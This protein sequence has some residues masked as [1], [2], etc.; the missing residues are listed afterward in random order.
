MLE[1][2]HLGGRTLPHAVLMM[3]PEA[4]E[5]NAT[6]DPAIRGFAE[7]HASLIEPWD[8][9]AC[10]TFTDGT[11]LGAVLDRNGLRP[12]RWWLTTDDTVVLASE[13]G[14]LP[15]PP[16]KVLERGRLQPGRMFLVDTDQGRILN[17]A[18]VKGALAAEHPYRDWVHAGL[19][20]L[21]DLPPREHVTVSH[22]SVLQRQKIFGYTE[23]ELR[24]LITPMAATGAEG[25]GS[26]GTDTPEAVLSEPAAADLR[27]LHPAVRA[28]HQPAAGR[29]PGGGRHLAVLA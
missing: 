15:I 29:H 16:E 17:D 3:I 11:V 24:V 19:M 14:V 5:N 7:F 6:L 10:V 28:G 26:M 1:L 12:G 2:L 21:A 8:G 9:P 18:E 13:A 23:E 25:I 27:L 22:R 20:R 4:W